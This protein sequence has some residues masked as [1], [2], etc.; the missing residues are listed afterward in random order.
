MPRANRV[1]HCPRF[2]GV[3]VSVSVL[4]LGWARRMKAYLCAVTLCLCSRAPGNTVAPPPH[5]MWEPSMGYGRAGG[6]G[7]SCLS[8]FDHV[9]V[10]PRHGSELRVVTL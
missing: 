6:A 1:H 7:G 3:R 10:F 2:V 4:Y 8:A 9:C 5:T